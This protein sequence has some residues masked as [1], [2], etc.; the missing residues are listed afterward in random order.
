MKSYVIENAQIFDGSGSPY[1]PGSIRIEGERI[2]AVVA[3]DLQL[4]RDGAEVID[5]GGRVLMP[6]LVDAHTHLAFPSS[7]ER[8]VPSFGLP[9]EESLL[10]SA[11]HPAFCS[12]T[13]SPALI[14]PGRLHRGSMLSFATRSRRAGFRVRA[15]APA[16]S[17]SFRLRWPNFFT[18]TQAATIPDRTAFA[19]T[20]SRRPRP[21]SRW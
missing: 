16:P 2:A 12:I 7:I 3:G 13:A 5:A 4:P 9:P 11:R 17:S 1:F 6:G 18:P 19:D 21:V 15:C 10:I 14:P 20:S 8:I